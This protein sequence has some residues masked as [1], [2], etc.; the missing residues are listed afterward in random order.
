MGRGEDNSSES[1]VEKAGNSRSKTKAAAKVRFVNLTDAEKARLPRIEALLQRLDKWSE[2][3]GAAVLGLSDDTTPNPFSALA[4]RGYPISAAAGTQQLF[5]HIAP[6]IGKAGID[7]ERRDYIFK[8]LEEVGI[9]QKVTVATGKELKA[10]AD[11][12][13]YGIHRRAKSANSAYALTDEARTLLF[14]TS[15]EEWEEALDEFIN[16]DSM[17]RL[18]ARQEAAVQAL[19]KAAKSLSPHAALIVT[20]I[21]ALQRSVAQGFKLAYIDDG[22]GPRGREYEEQLKEI[23]LEIAL[24]DLQPDAI[25]VKS[26]SRQL[27][28]IDAVIS[29]GEIDAVRYAQMQQ[30]AED[31]GYSV[32]GAVTCYESWTDFGRRQHNHKNIAPGTAVWIAEDG[33]KLVDIKSIAS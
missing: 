31:A 1:G 16:E 3:M 7:R 15:D 11:P 10:G 25:L 21:E 13:T 2:E 6:K 8:P 12:I 4:S 23:G 14:D 30:W 5:K 27:W 24:K 17:R 20:S 9:V 32:V 22:D 33:G 29:D 18:R 28:F 19:Q 26:D